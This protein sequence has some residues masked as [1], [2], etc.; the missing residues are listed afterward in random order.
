V[1][2]KVWL[3]ADGRFVIGDGGLALLEGVARLGSLAAA[4]RDIG[5]SY[6][7]AWGYIRR[8]ESVLGRPLLAPRP[9]KG[10][11]RG[12]ELTDDGH[13]LLGRL[14]SARARLDAALGESGPTLDEIAA[15]GGGRPRRRL[16]A[17]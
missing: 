6:R 2:T 5:W 13:R 8:A 1:R 4:V 16:S 7:H 14:R 10:R 12:A 9:G 15:R 3:E 11:D 17:R